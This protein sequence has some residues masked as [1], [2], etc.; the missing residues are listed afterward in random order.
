MHLSLKLLGALSSVLLQQCDA[1]I[2]KVLQSNF[3]PVIKPLV[4]SRLA[5]V[6]RFNLMAVESC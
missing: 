5:R 2:S 3:P 6:F 4:I 1:A